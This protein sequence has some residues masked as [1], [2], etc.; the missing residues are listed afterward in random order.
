LEYL[1]GDL[2]CVKLNQSQKNIDLQFDQ[3]AQN[4]NLESLFSL[5]EELQ[6]SKRLVEQN[7]QTQLIIDQLFIKLM[8]V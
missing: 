8:N 1:L 2:I 5:Y 6:Q 7:V 4:Y 3:L